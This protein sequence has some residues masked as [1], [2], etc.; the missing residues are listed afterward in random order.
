MLHRH[1][2][3]NMQQLSKT[4]N[5]SVDVI[6]TEASYCSCII[7]DNISNSLTY[8]YLELVLAVPCG[9]LLDD[10]SPVG[11]IAGSSRHVAP[12]YAHHL[13]IFVYLLLVL[14]ST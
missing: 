7:Y 13:Q 1:L 12:V 11:T 5:L 8:E 14:I 2:Y 10:S 3:L 4:H 6:I 9:T